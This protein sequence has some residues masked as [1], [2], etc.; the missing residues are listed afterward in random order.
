[1]AERAY[2]SAIPQNQP[3]RQPEQQPRQTPKQQPSHKPKKHTKLEKFLFVFTLVLL[4]GLATLVV[5]RQ[6]QIHAISRDIQA[7][8]ISIGKVQEQNSELK[9]QVNELS[10]P[11]RIWE[12]AKSLGLTQNEHNVKVVPVK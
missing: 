3:Q 5:S 9:M 2:Y 12:I 7:K 11:E 1:M 4:L 6:T 10:Q 8:E